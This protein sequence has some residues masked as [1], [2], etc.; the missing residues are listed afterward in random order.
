[1]KARADIR[2][3]DRGTAMRLLE[4]LANY[5]QT[6]AG[7]AKQLHGS[8]RRRIVSGLALGALSSARPAWRRLKSSA[9]AI[10]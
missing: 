5:L 6:E 2:A 7:N 1:V 4:C 8:I 3:I 9:F 10:G